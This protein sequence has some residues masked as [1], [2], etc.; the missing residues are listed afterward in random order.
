MGIS[1]EDFNKGFSRIDLWLRDKDMD[2]GGGKIGI[3]DIDELKKHPN[4]DTVRISGLTQET[5]EYFIRTYG[6]QLKAIDF[7]KNRQVEDWSLLGSLPQL[8]YIKFFHN[9]R[10]ASL[11]DMSGNVSLKGICIEDFTRLE[12]IDGISKAPVLEVLSLGNAFSS[13][14]ILDSLLPLSGSPV[15]KLSFFGKDIVN[16]DLSFL[17]RL[18]KLESYDFPTNCYTTE[19]VAWIAANFPNLCGFAIKPFITYNCRHP[20]TGEKEETLIIVGKRKPHFTMKGNEEKLRRYIDKFEKLKKSYKN[21]PY[22]VAFP[23]E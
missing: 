16:K 14:M 21:I 1:S 15:K 8:E 5:F 20:E 11:W 13:K 3:S 12:N 6:K 19:Q 7:F 4:T 9:Q 18:E 17:F 22:S 2:I 23:K 10:I